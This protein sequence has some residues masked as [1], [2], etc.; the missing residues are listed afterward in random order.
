MGFSSNVICCYTKRADALSLDIEAR[1][2]RVVQQ[3]C[4]GLALPY[5]CGVDRAQQQL[6]GK[7]M[8]REIRLLQYPINLSAALRSNYVDPCGSI[9]IKIIEFIRGACA[10]LT[11]AGIMHYDLHTSNIVLKWLGP[12]AACMPEVRIID[13]VLAKDYTDVSSNVRHAR[14]VAA[15]EPMYDWYFFCFSL[16][17]SYKLQKVPLPYPLAV[18][19]AAVLAYKTRMDALGHEWERVEVS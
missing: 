9:V 18:E 14:T 5:Y 17:Q 6:N 2:I 15:L 4:P 16:M 3:R 8:W 11:E 19:E 13:W 12:D 7:R 10:R 1:M